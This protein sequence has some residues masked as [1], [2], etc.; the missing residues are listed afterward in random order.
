MKSNAPFVGIDVSKEKLDVATSSGRENWSTAN[1]QEGIIRLVGQLQGME[2]ALIVLEA[3]GGLEMAAA[4]AL[5][6]ADL[7]VVVVN[8]RQ[9]RDF[10]KAMGKLAKT[11]KLDAQ[12]IAQFGERIRP[13]PRALPDAQAQHLQALIARRRQL[14][15]MLT[16]ERNRCHTASLMVRKRIEKHIAWLEVEIEALN[17]DLDQIIHRSPLWQAKATLLRSV[18]GIGPVM[19]RTLLAELPELGRLN[20]KEIAALVGVAPLNRDSGTSRGRRSVWGGRA[21]VRAALYMAALVGTR[22]NPVIKAFYQ[23]LIDAGKPSKVALTACMRKLLTIVNAMLR[24]GTLWC[25]NY[26]HSSY[27]HS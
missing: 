2:P 13:T 20:R 19:T 23:R 14:V 21:S 3:S 5:A 9:V 18:P 12:V 22:Y 8:P 16:A 7:P 25:P 11:D 6:T 24:H 1:S 27:R 4:V 26:A 17:H 10:A 15:K